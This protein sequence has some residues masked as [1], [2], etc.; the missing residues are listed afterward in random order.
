MDIEALKQQLQE[1]AGLDG[2]QAER[3]ARVALEFFTDQLP[4]A[5]ELLDKAGGVDQVARRLGG[6]FG[7]RD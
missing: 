5:G 1:R 2:E 3:A 6:L 7:K 4:Q